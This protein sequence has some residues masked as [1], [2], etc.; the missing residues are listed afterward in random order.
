[1]NM[2]RERRGRTRERDVGVDETIIGCRWHL[3]FNDFVFE[4]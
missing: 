2:R 4:F 1:M 3:P